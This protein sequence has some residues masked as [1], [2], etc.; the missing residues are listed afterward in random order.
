MELILAS[1]FFFKTSISV[2]KVARMTRVLEVKN[3]MMQLLI[4]DTKT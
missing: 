1:E 3:L 4:Q 2:Q